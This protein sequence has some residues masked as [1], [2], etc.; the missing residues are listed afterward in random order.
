MPVLVPLARPLSRRRRRTLPL[1]ALVAAACGGR[2]AQVPEPL[3]GQQ[4]APL[5]PAE[6]AVMALPV[7]VSLGAVRAQLE[8]ALPLADSLDRA[9]CTT[10]GGVVC[11]QYVYRRDPLDVRMEGDRFDLVARLRYRGRVAVPGMGGVGSCGYAPEPM[12]RAELRVST[13]LFWRADWRLASRGTTLAA[14]LLDPCRVTVLRADATPLMRR[15]ADAQ[16]RELTRTVDS[17]VP[18]VVDLRA[19]AD[20]LWQAFQQPVAL[21]TTGRSWLTLGAERVALAPVAGAGGAIRSAVL[22][23]A[24]P[25]VVLGEQP[26]ASARPL[27]ALTLA[28]PAS[29]LRIPADVVLPYDELGRRA[30]GLLAGEAAGKGIAVREVRLWGVGDTAVVRVDVDGSVRGTFFLVGRVGYD[31]TER[32]VRI[33]GLRYTVESA[34]LMTKLKVTL[35]A[36]LIRRALDQATGGG[37]MHVGAQLDAARRELSA[38]LNGPLAPGVAVGGG[39]QEVRITGIHSTPDAF[40][41]RVR[42]EGTAQLFV[43]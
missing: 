29:G 6:A 33:D 23:I 41:V 19:A 8:M 34:G 32:V 5:P 39:I 43:Q 42:L 10:M 1:A 13:S 4:A 16:L 36:P 15:M 24:H 21:D 28:P 20:S 17:L 22:L 18:A 38:R 37:R 27:P 7:T 9:R 14:D 3:A 25:R 12:R 31:P 26:T 2:G 11:H 35:G 30:T 40:V